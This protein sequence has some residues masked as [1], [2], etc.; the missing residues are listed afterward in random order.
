MINLKEYALSPEVSRLLAYCLSNPE[1]ALLKSIAELYMKREGLFLVGVYRGTELAGLLGYAMKAPRQ[2]I[3]THLA[4]DP[5]FRREGIAREML[6]E[7]IHELKLK[8]VGV[9]AI[10]SGKDFYEAM[11]FSCVPV[12]DADGGATHY[13]CHLTIQWPIE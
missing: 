10:E 11:G 4:V 7:L 8:W 6:T 9:D 12:I 13:N 1:E 5:I 2:M 3:V